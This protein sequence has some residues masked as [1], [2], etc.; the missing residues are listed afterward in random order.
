MSFK[1]VQGDALKD[2]DAETRALFAKRENDERLSY[3]LAAVPRRERHNLPVMVDEN[4]SYMKD[5]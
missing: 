1:I 5:L 3:V 2:F 4:N